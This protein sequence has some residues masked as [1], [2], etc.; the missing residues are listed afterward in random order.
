LELARIEP[1]SLANKAFEVELTFSK[2]ITNRAFIAQAVAH[3]PVQ[4]L[5]ISPSNDSI[6]LQRIRSSHAQKWDV[7]DAGTAFRF[8]V[9]YACAKGLDCEIYGTDRLHKRP[10]K[11]LVDALTFLGFSITYLEKDGFAPLKISSKQLSPIGNSVEIDAS[12]SSQFVSALMLVAPLLPNGLNL[13]IL[14]ENPASFPYIQTTF[15]LMQ[16]WGFDIGW[17]GKN[18]LKIGTKRMVNIASYSIEK[19]WSAAGFWYLLASLHPKLE[20]QLNGLFLNSIQADRHTSTIYQNIGISSTENQQGIRI[21]NELNHT[22]NP[23]EFNLRNTPDLFPCLAVALA[24]LSPEQKSKFTLSG[25]ETLSFKESNRLEAIQQE[26][27]KF[28]VDLVEVATGKWQ[29]Q[30]EFIPRSATIETYK[31]HR[32]AMAFAMLATQVELAIEQPSVVLKSYPNFWEEFS[33][34]V[35]KQ[36]FKVSTRI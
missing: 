4:L 34:L 5:G 36:G 32:I 6:V 19:D 17:T 21:K 7:E 29:L 3:N 1:V 2:S 10:I 28:G 14:P 22:E 16:E 26:L 11:P 13:S 27:Q 12:Q 18:K 24:V 30:G 23:V 20:I 15:Q 9:A 33:Y 31:D 8:L 35:G 25:L